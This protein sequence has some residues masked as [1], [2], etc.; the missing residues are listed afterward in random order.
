[1]KYGHAR[2]PLV[3]SF[4]TGGDI[5]NDNDCTQQNENILAKG[6]VGRALVNLKHM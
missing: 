3:R 2:G 6:V 5:L 1:M 4:P